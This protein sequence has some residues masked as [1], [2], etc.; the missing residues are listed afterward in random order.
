MGEAPEYDEDESAEIPTFVL[1]SSEND[2]I[3]NAE[4]L[5]GLLWLTGYLAK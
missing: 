4:Q 5:Q 1:N 2:G 3:Q